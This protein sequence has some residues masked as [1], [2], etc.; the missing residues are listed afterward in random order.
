MR[1]IADAN[2]QSAQDKVE[3]QTK[4]ANTLRSLENQAFVN[5]AINKQVQDE[6]SRV[7]T[8]ANKFMSGVHSKK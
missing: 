2:E 5:N 8:A 4:I 6:E 1:A 3:E 7:I